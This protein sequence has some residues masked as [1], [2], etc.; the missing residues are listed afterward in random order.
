MAETKQSLFDYAV[1][2]PAARAN[3]PVNRAQPKSLLDYM[4]ELDLMALL[5][6]TGIPERASLANELL[7]PLAAIPRAQ[8]ASRDIFEP[9]RSIAQR[10]G[11]TGNMLTELAGI[12]VPMAAS[13][14][15]GAPAAAAVME[16][17]IGG[18]PTTQA[19]SDAARG[20]LTDEVRPAPAFGK[21]WTD[22][23]HW[24]RSPEDFNAFDA[25]K[26]VGSTSRLGPHVGT[27]WAA[28]DRF[29]SF[30]EPV[31][32]TMPLKADLRR[33]FYDPNTNMPWKE[34]DLEM[35]ISAMADEHGID[36][37]DVPPMLRRLL[38]KQGFT[39]VPY[40]NDV[41]DAGSI[42]NIMLTDRGNASDAVLRSRFAK[43]DPRRATV[44]DL[45]AAVAAGLPLGLM[46]MPTDEE[47]Y[48]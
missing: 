28:E 14:R 9:D 18:S 29:K 3:A 37:R 4:S 39:N 6:S 12:A 26:S 27:K 46:S 31:G 15:A 10:I 5:D 24:S 2:P 35:F 43:F 30:E 38:A 47:Q 16:G 17:L 22:V 45:S 32:F 36:R 48:R 42:S 13:A 21:N 44:E 41:E 7:N 11:S 33:P 8:A 23:Y 25:E 40:V 34:L 1:P 20:F 19:A